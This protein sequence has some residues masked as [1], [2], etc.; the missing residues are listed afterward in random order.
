MVTFQAPTYV[1]SCPLD[2][3]GNYSVQAPAGDYVVY[4]PMA[5]QKD[6]TFVPPANEPDAVRHINLIDNKFGSP[7]TS[8]LKCTVA[9]SQT[10]DILVTTPEK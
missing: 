5:T 1:T 10:Y 6:E 8:P 3:S 4:I 9:G 7:E 2:S